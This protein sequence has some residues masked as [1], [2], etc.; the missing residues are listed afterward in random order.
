MKPKS[1]YSWELTRKKELLCQQASPAVGSQLLYQGRTIYPVAVNCDMRY[2]EIAVTTNFEG[3][4]LERIPIS[5]I[6][7]MEIT[8]VPQSRHLCTVCEGLGYVLKSSSSSSKETKGEYTELK[9]GYEHTYGPSTTT[10]TILKRVTCDKCT[11]Y[12]M[13]FKF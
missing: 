6:N 2:I 7:N 5:E 11:G 10:K 12:G 4:H 1:I 13:L 3:S 8:S 9:G